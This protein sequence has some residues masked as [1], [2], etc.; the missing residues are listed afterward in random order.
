MLL[1]EIIQQ[2]NDVF[3]DKVSDEDKLRFANSIELV[4][5]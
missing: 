1:A 3:A 2:L 4:K 5:P